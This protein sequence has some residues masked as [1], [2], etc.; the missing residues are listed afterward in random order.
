MRDESL[1]DDDRKHLVPAEAERAFLKMVANGY[2]L[3]VD[4]F[5]AANRI[6][7]W[8]E[9]GPA[10]ADHYHFIESR[11]LFLWHRR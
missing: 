1:W 6:M 11:G 4:P 7:V 9:D 5:N 2:L 3:A 10:S 8:F